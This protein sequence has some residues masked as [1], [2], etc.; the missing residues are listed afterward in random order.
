MEGYFKS[1][2]ISG[3]VFVGFDEH[4]TKLKALSKRI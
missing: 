4:V 3:A 2:I 1:G